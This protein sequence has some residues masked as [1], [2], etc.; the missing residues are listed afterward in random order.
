[1]R[2][3]SSH[4]SKKSAPPLA[5]ARQRLARHL[6][7]SPPR[8][9]ADGVWQLRGGLPAREMNVYLVRDTHP[10]TG[11]AGVLAFDTGVRQMAPAIAHHAATL[12]GLTRIVLGHSH[13]DHRGAAPRLGVPVLCHPDE[14]ADA[15]TD[16]G[17]HY[18]NHSALPRHGQILGPQLI[19]LWDGG[20]VAI[21]A[22]LAEGE[23]IAGFEVIHLPGHAPGLIALWRAEDRLAL[24]S[25]CFYTLDPLTGRRGPPRIP[26]PAFNHNTDQA[27]ES[28]RKLATLQPRA[29]WP[30]HAHP[31]TGNVAAQLQRAA[32]QP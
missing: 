5:D 12:G 23:E 19:R 11:R 14:R 21:A 8:R 16:G 13:I 25:D 4:N 3:V 7:A 1:M 18:Y 15:E 17:T 27:R 10:D 32:D 9:I 26:H 31:L 2:A 29:A 28:I 20:P 24:S 30:G 22:T 6:F